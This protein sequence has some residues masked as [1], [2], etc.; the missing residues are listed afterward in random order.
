MPEDGYPTPEEIERIR[1]WE[2]KR[3]NEYVNLM[4][5]IKS[6]WWAAEWG[7]QEEE[8]SEAY[9]YH[10]STGGWS[11]NEEIIMAM[12]ANQM[13]WLFCWVSTRRGGHY[14]FSIRKTK[15]TGSIG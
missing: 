15:P 5:F 9:K 2:A 12:A 7:W 6:C 11:G 8:T 13:F 3:S 4:H 14:E 1:N 10:I